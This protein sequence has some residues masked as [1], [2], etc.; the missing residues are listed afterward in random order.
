MSFAVDL[1]FL[2]RIIIGYCIGSIPSGYLIARMYGIA[3]IRDH[4]SGSI[5]ATNVSRVLGLKFFFIVFLA[6]FLKSYLY[7][8]ALA[9]Y[10]FSQFDLMSA[11]IFLLIGNGYSLFFGSRSGKGVATTCG[12]LCALAPL[13]LLILLC[14]W[15]I[16]FLLSK[17]V[18]IASTILFICMPVCAYFFIDFFADAAFLLPFTIFVSLWGLWLHRNNIYL[19]TRMLTQI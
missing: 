15:L 13:F 17:T 1:F 11:S 2:A 7:V 5:G 6:D 14:G 18:G 4:G 3:D 12:V 8:L 9:H 10:D 19:Y 16:V